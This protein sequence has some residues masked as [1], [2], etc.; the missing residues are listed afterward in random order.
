MNLS[1]TGGRVVSAIAANIVMHTKSC[2]N[3]LIAGSDKHRC[4]SVG[5]PQVESQSVA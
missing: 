2:L 4:R 3:R 5:V 1:D